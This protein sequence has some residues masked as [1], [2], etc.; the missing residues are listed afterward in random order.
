MK[1]IAFLFPGVGSQY[2][3]MSKSLYEQFKVFKDTI[4]EADDILK[5]DIPGLSF[6]PGK[7]TELD[8]LENA[9]CI[10]LAFSMAT[11]RVYMQEI[12][13]KPDFCLG[14]SLGEYSALCSAGVMSFSDAL[15]LVK[16]RG[17]IVNQ[18]S[19]SLNGTMA[20]I[21]NLDIDKVEKVCRDVSREGEEVF[22]SAYDSPTQTSISGHTDT[23]MKA[24][25]ILEKEGAIVY[26][27]KLS[28]PFHSPLMK[29]AAEKMRAVLSQYDY[30]NPS[31]TVIANRHALPYSDK[32]S[33]LEN[34]SLQ[35]ISPVRWKASLEYIIAQEADLAV[36]IGPKN[37]LKFLTAKNTASLPVFT[38]DNLKD[39]Q[40]LQD[41]LIIKSEDYL[42]TMGKCLGAAVSTKNR[43]DDPKEYEEKVI[44]PY[45]KIEAWYNQ[46]TSGSGVPSKDQVRESLDL[47]HGILTTKKVPP[48]EIDLWLK[49]VTNNKGL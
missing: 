43:N 38:T 14:H 42:Y 23:L 37:V 39:L 12:G 5:L 11:F 8:K 24:A 4:V 32:D 47:L 27:L 30:K 21:I 16:Q 15:R 2:V 18:V 44:K 10:L 20:W 3:G 31:C 33:V 13:F 19:S 40:S 25:R 7:K 29:D 1:K 22:I 6:S 28:G 34:L 46:L 17:F 26:P 48:Q 49:K 41:E 35:L 9:Q 45:R 36:E